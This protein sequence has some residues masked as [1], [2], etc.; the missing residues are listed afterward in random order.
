MT[1]SFI[2][3]IYQL[4]SIERPLNQSKLNNMMLILKYITVKQYRTQQTE[5]SSDK[6][7]KVKKTDYLQ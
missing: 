5:S 2:D 3:K 7:P 4:L 1:N 6:Q